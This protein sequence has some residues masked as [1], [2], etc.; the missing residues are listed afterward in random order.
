MPL[1]IAFKAAFGTKK[2]SYGALS[3]FDSHV[4]LIRLCKK[5]ISNSKNSIWIG[6]GLSGPIDFIMW[7][8]YSE[9]I[10]DPDCSMMFGREVPFLANSLPV[11]SLCPGSRTRFGEHCSAITFTN[12]QAILYC[13]RF[14]FY[15]FRCDF[16]R[17]LLTASSITANSVF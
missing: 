3:D 1:F 14:N 4:K 8:D 7:L 9:F 10:E 12:M 13:F 16:L 11:M 15:R 6:K 2:G 17:V 5:T